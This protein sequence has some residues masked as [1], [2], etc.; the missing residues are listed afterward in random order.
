M[1]IRVRSETTLQLFHPLADKLCDIGARHVVVLEHW[2][3]LTAGNWMTAEV[4]WR[5]Q[6]HRLS[7]ERLCYESWTENV[8][9]M[10]SRLQVLAVQLRTMTA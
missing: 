7:T 5:H 4:V 2:E 10:Y 8:F 3:R 6:H 9:A 1:L